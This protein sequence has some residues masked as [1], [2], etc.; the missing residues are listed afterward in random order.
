LG[1]LADFATVLI[2]YAGKIWHDIV[3]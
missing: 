2:P 3:E 1:F